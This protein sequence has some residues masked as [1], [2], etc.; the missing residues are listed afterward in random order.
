MLFTS[1]TF[2]KIADWLHRL[3]I[4]PTDTQFRDDLHNHAINEVDSNANMGD[5]EIENLN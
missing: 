1:K 2:S 5:F 3:R 4:T